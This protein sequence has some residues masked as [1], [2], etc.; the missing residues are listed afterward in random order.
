MT[1]TTPAAA[2]GASTPPALAITSA[3]PELDSSADAA[4]VHSAQADATQEVDNC[5]SSLRKV[6]RG[7]LS[8]QDAERYDQASR[9]IQSARDSLAEQDYVA[10]QSLARKA[11]ILIRLLASPSANS[12]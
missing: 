4:Q 3:E 2:P 12:H 1:A 8:A 11:A 10:A 7:Q 6:A 9:L 5:T